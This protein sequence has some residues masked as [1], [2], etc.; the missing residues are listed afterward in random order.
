MYDIPL[1]GDH[2]QVLGNPVGLFRNLGTGIR[3]FTSGVSGLRHGDQQ[4]FKDGAKTLVR[5]GTHGLSN[6]ISK[7][8]SS[9]SRGLA[10][11]DSSFLRQREEQKDYKDRPEDYKVGFRQGTAHLGK[12]VYSGF[13]GLAKKPAEGYAT[14]GFKGMAQ[15]MAFG[16]AGLI[17]KPASGL[18]D[19]VANTTEGIRN[20]TNPNGKRQIARYREPRALAESRVLVP[21]HS[22][23]P[24]YL[25]LFERL[26]TYASSLPQALGGDLSGDRYVGHYVLQDGVLIFTDRHCVLSSAVRV[27]PANIVAS[28][29]IA[30]L[31]AAAGG[32]GAGLGVGPARGGEAA[33]RVPLS[34]TLNDE[35]EEGTACGVLSFDLDKSDEGGEGGELGG[36]AAHLEPS[37]QAPAAAAAAG[38]GEGEGEGKVEGSAASRRGGDDGECSEG[39]TPSAPA[40]RATEP[41]QDERERGALERLEGGA[42]GRAGADEEKQGGGW[43][44]AE[45]T[46]R[47]KRCGLNA[48]LVHDEVKSCSLLWHVP[49]ADVG[50]IKG[51]DGTIG[52]GA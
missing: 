22:T 6:T 52:E 11:V 51:E 33:R 45:G 47:K 1:P 3:A 4:S 2:L 23:A 46:E 7:V 19:L 25:E 42:G 35:Q 16:V 10:S 20:Q 9:A 31:A 32:A 41:R 15:G 34:S 5:H 27:T 30:G 50:G 13:S 44:A 36:N 40:Q 39:S 29:T 48:H 8:T 21:L 18:L 12:C 49:W 43:E 17:C 28:D 14:G 26:A 38:A 37:E 24:A